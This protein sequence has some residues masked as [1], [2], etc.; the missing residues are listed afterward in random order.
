M[1]RKKK[2]SRKNTHP[3]LF[4]YNGSI[5]YYQEG[6]MLQLYSQLTMDE[7]QEIVEETVKYKIFLDCLKEYAYPALEEKWESDDDYFRLMLEVALSRMRNIDALLIAKHDQEEIKKQYL[8]MME[9][10]VHDMRKL[11][12]DV[13]EAKKTTLKIIASDL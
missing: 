11:I 6:S 5:R 12:E 8:K 7:W 1:K 9:V 4:A 10:G 3:T 2:K 13:K